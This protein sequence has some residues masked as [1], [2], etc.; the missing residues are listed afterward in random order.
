MWR[1]NPSQLLAAILLDLLVGDPPGWPH[2]ARLTGRLSTRYEAIL[3]RKAKR[4]VGLGILFWGLVTGTIFAGYTIAYFC[5]ASSVGR[6]YRYSIPSL[7]TSP[8]PPR[9]WIATCKR[10]F[11]LSLPVIWGRLAGGSHG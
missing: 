3:T 4:S 2:I 11:G 1:A 8:S 10:F 7:F 5:A 9:I 6:R